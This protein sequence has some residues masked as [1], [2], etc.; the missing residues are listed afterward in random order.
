MN[1]YLASS[2]VQDGAEGRK[3]LEIIWIMTQAQKVRKKQ[4]PITLRI[5]L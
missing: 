5:S 3:F 4:L 2:S 1:V